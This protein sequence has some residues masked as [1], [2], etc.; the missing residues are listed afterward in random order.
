MPG[1][2]EELIRCLVLQWSMKLS[3]AQA[4]YSVKVRLC[5]CVSE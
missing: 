5:K 1:C 2:L 4:G 3:G